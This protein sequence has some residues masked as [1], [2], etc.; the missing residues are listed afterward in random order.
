M[1]V[2]EIILTFPALPDGGGHDEKKTVFQMKKGF[3]PMPGVDGWQL[4]NFPVISGA[5][6]LA[7]LEI[8]ERAG[9][10]SLHKKKY[11]PDRL[12]GISSQRDEIRT[13]PYHHSIEPQASAVV[14]FP[15]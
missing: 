5:A 11:T 3:Q 15:S 10:K 9:M 13:I 12:F 14:S 1:S 6:Q 2:M 4:S 7:S 8:F